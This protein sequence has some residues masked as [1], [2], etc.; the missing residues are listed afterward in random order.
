[1]LKPD[2]SA[3]VDIDAMR[4]LTQN[5]GL[6]CPGPASFCSTT[7]VPS[8]LGARRGRVGPCLR[9]RRRCAKAAVRPLGEVREVVDHSAAE[10][11]VHRTG[12]IGAVLLQG[13]RREP[14]I[15][16]GLRRA[17]EAL[18]HPDA[19]VETSVWEG[20]ARIETRRERPVRFAPANDGKVRHHEEVS[21]SNRAVKHVIRTVLNTV[22][23]GQARTEPLA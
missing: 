15:L 14:Q 20:Q 21:A 1:M 18:T 4:P 11:P 22:L 7:V 16:A 23:N 6:S 13:P 5:Q 19:H 9:I 17:K 3:L 2:V 10:L 8:R 12:A